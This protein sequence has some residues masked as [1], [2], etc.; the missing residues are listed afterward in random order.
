LGAATPLPGR[1]VHPFTV[2]VIV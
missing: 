1:L 2:C